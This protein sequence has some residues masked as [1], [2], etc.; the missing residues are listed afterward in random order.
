MPAFTYEKIAPPVQTE[1]GGPVPSTTRRN[2]LVRFLDRLTASRIERSENGARRM[3]RLK[4]KY[5][6]QRE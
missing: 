1:A 4:H 5:R 3:Q 2:A 6:K